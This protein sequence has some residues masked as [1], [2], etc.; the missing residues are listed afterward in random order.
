MTTDQ[1]WPAVL[2][3]L[4]LQMTQATFDTWLR[5]TRLLKYENGVYVIGVK[6]GYAKD[7]LENR[8]LGTIRRTLTRQVGKTV[9]VKFVVWDKTRSPQDPVSL[10]H[11]LEDARHP[12]T[13]S[14]SVAASCP[15]PIPTNLNPRYLFDN[16]VVGPGNRLAHAASIAITENPGGAYNPFFIYGGVGLGKTHLLNAIGHIC[17]AQSLR[18]LY[19]SSERFTNDLIEAIRTHTTE[20]FREKY[21]TVDVLLIDDIQFIA[22]KESTQEEFFHTFNTLHS[23]GKQIVISSDRAPKSMSTLE[24]RLCSR[25]EWGLIADIQS[26]DW[27]TRIAILRSKAE[28]YGNQIPDEILELVASRIQCNIRELEGALNRVLAMA[29]LTAQPLTEEV[30]EKALSTLLP[31]QPHLT[32]DQILGQVAHYFGIEVAALQGKSRSRAIARPRQIAMYLI[33]EET[34]ESLPQIGGLLGGRDHTTVLYGCE[35][36]AELMEQ[37]ANIRREVITLRQRIYDATQVFHTPG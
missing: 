4:E 34:G 2:G 10:L 14:T 25:F 5:D 32:P 29:Q 7:W 20:A 35:R 18:V 30:A 1:V 36:I 8:L 33:R 26:P 22:G 9:D 19:I 11:Q 16:F 24:E 27:E 15:A 3:E 21:R 13:P 31:Q 23:N 28:A 6:S 37:D 17:H 12:L